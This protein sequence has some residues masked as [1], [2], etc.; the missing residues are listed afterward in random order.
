MGVTPLLAGT[1]VL[2]HSESGRFTFSYTTESDHYERVRVGLR[3]RHQVVNGLTA[4]HAAE[5]LRD[6]G[7][8]ISHSAIEEGLAKAEWPGRLELVPGQPGILLDGAHNPAGAHSLRAY[9]DEFV[10]EPVTLVLGILD[11]KDA[12]EIA[13]I[14][15]PAAENVVLTRPSSPRA[16]D[17]RTLT[18]VGGAKIADSAPEALDVARRLSGG[19]GLIVVAGSLYLVGETRALL[20]ARSPEPQGAR[21]R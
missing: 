17:P 8:A 6:S 14:L 11:D 9:L 1:P 10:H 5:A 15:L 7:F 3:G 12:D 13:S 2:H 19:E 20:G 16:R 21:V 4:I 18:R